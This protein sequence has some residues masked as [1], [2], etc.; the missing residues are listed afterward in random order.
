MKSAVTTVLY[1]RSKMGCVCQIPTVDS[2]LFR[3]PFN[4]CKIS[5]TSLTS[6]MA[7]LMNN[8]IPLDFQFKALALFFPSPT[9]CDNVLSTR[10]SCAF[11]NGR[12]TGNNVVWMSLYMFTIKSKLPVSI[13]DDGTSKPNNKKYLISRNN[14]TNSGSKLTFNKVNTDLDAASAADGETRPNKEFFSFVCDVASMVP[15]QLSMF[16]RSKS[17]TC[18]IKFVYALIT[19]RTSSRSNTFLSNVFN[20]L[21]GMSTRSRRLFDH[22][23]AP[24]IGGKL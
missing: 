13:A 1:A 19:S 14:F 20:L 2:T 7:S 22:V 11:T 8:S 17:E 9:P 23:N 18:P 6:L 5:L 4:I 12:S 16:K 15:P 21:I 10:S 24:A 3:L